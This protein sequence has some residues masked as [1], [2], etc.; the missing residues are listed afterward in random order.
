[1]DLYNYEKAKRNLKVNNKWMKRFARH[2]QLQPFFI[3]TYEV[4]KNVEN[5]L[6]IIYK[7]KVEEKDRETFEKRYNQLF[8]K[9]K[10]IYNV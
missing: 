10:D 8:N 9:Y 4:K 3:S 2:F 1:M 7:G 6:A 5:I